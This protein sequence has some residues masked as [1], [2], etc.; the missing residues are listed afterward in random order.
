MRHPVDTHPAQAHNAAALHRLVPMVRAIERGEKVNV[1]E[2]AILRSVNLR[3]GEADLQG[4]YQ[5]VGRF[6]ALSSEH[7]T[8]TRWGGRPAYHHQVRSHV[9]NLC[10]SGDL[11]RV[12]RGRYSLTARG[13]RR[14]TP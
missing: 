4:I 3:E 13:R 10:Q 9:T 11:V 1:W 2:V 5:T 7:L 6:V 14:V 8:P 12:G